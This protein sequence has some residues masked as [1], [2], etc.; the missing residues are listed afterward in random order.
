MDGT[1]YP[2]GLKRGQMSIQARAMAIAD[3]F[4]ALTAKDR[5]YKQGKKLSE[6]LAILKKLK[7]NQ[8]IAPDLYDVF[9]TEKVYRQYAGNSWMTTNLMWIK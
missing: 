9:I 1:S 8:H 5:P 6:A 3:I 4:E 2:K 7:D